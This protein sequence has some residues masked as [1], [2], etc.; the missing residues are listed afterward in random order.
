MA[1]SRTRVADKRKTRFNPAYIGPALAGSVRKLSPLT[2]WRN[3]V[4]LIVE[5][6][7]LLTT[8]LTV[9]DA[10]HGRNI[11]FNLQ[12]S[13]WL[14][15]TVLFANFAESLAEAQGAARAE[16]LRK[17]RHDLAA[18]VLRPDGS[19]EQV[20]ATR[21]HK[22]DVILLAEG[23]VVAGD[24]EVIEGTS[25]VDESAITG[26]SA[27]VI[28]EAGGDRSAVTAGSR[29]L[30]GTVRVRVT[31]NPGET[32]LD[33]MIKMVEGTKRHKTPNEI[34]LEILLVGLTVL[35]IVVVAALPAFARY[36][37]VTTTVPI[38]VSLLV[39]LMPTTIGGLLPAIGIAGT[40]RLLAR[41]V[42][43][44]SGRAIEASGDV[45]AV[46]LDK[47]GTITL[48]NRMA[49]EIMPASGATREEATEAA[50][51]SS[52][53]DE[54]PEGRSIV[55]LCKNELGIKGRDIRTPESSTFVPFSAKT[56]MSGIDS[57]TRRIRKGSVD[58]V[59]A[60]VE[61]S[62]GSF[63]DDLAR[64]VDAVAGR[65]DTPL[66]IAEDRVPG[67]TGSGVQAGTGT[68][69][70]SNP[71]TLVRVLGI[72]RLKDVLK[73]GIRGRL[74]Q[75][76]QMGIRSVM[77]TGDNPL[78]AASIAAEA[79]LD[80]FVA[81]ARPEAKLELIRKYQSDGQLVA[82]I[83]DGT[84]DAPALA[85]ADVAVAM[86]AGTQAAREAANMIDLDSNP[87]KLLD[88]VEVGKQ[89]LITRGALTT[90]S[91]ANDVSKYFAIVPAIF[92]ASYPELGIL[93]VMHLTS[94]ASAVLAAVIF[95]AVII[96]LL[97]PLALRGV[98][99]RTSSASALL[100]LNLLV[101]GAGGLLLPFVGI[102]L[103]DLIL[104]LLHLA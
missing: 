35:F 39:C 101:Y 75:L 46:L 85:Q 17:S 68:L 40:E 47:T 25:L 43:A 99:F 88:I 95:N 42:I 23:E 61:E 4:M 82:M 34:A 72:I 8:L 20:P 57:G 29:I 96:P 81:Q 21:L 64:E 11:G 45:N 53:S 50:L 48:G 28:R 70:P 91:I 63:A 86:N 73:Q 92:A 27:P 2:L 32:F 67:F 65:G 44:L 19:I 84:N 93:N 58:A 15:F 94:P 16:S 31:V 36:M 59:R 90:F 10:V 97:I 69:G 6:G 66:V 5:A 13:V 22:D 14:W 102:K 104:T 24:G 62:G 7:S 103:F 55:V 98:R 77:I 49:A 83:G 26:E 33:N 100:R 1:S 30:S 76:R 3:P 71:G 56:R 80:D 41:N 37:H 79:G 60:W 51:L 9:L 78:T 12:I 74:A 18:R 87:T 89:I 54:T 38:L 52:L